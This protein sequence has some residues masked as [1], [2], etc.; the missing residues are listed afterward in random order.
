M[1]RRSEPFPNSYEEHSCDH[2]V[3][4]D[5]KTARSQKEK[6]DSNTFSEKTLHS[7][8]DQRKPMKRVIKA[9]SRAGTI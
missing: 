1:A 2:K 7:L 9:T 4:F 8:F 6:K 5:F 3:L